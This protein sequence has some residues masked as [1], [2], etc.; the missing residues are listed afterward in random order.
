[1]QVIGKFYITKK[2]LVQNW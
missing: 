1:M 2:V